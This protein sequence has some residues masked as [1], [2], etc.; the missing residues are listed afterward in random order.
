VVGRR[1]LAE[2]LG[3]WSVRHRKSAVLGWLLLVVTAAALGGVAGQRTL[4]TAETETGDTGRA[5]RILVDAGV[6]HPAGEM[7]LMHSER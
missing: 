6:E 4:T 7:V 3:G 2:A 1:N 5:A